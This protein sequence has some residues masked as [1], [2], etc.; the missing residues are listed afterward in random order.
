MKKTLYKKINKSFKGVKLSEKTL[1]K[2]SKRELTTLPKKEKEN[3]II[4]RDILKI[5]DRKA[6]IKNKNSEDLLND[7]YDE[8]KIDNK[9]VMAKLYNN[10]KR[11]NKMGLNPN[12]VTTKLNNIKKHNEKIK[13][14]KE[15]REEREN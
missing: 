4:L 13:E 2:L 5:V 8:K 9:R 15:V 6:K 3:R 10:K 14:L 1:N 11:L 12:R 7:I